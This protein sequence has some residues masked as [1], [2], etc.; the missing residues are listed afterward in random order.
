MKRVLSALVAAVVLVPALAQTEWKISTRGYGQVKAGM[1]TLEA[2][3][4][5][6]TRLKTHDNRPLDPSCDY[7]YP[8]KG[9]QGVSMMVERGKIAHVQLAGAGPQTRSGAAVG[10]SVDKLRQLYG[11]QLEIQPHKYDET[12]FYYYVWE[13]D[14]RYGIKFEIGGGKVTSI[15]AGDYTIGYVEGCA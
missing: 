12:G 2:A 3:R 15:F 1:S 5:M 4:W 9:F 13:Q 7:V 11:Q 8:E 14:K 6:G 10:D